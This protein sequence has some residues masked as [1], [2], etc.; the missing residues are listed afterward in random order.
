MSDF[1]AICNYCG[2]NFGEMRDNAIKL[3]LHIKNNHE[4]RRGKLKNC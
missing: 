4:H 1:D 2:I 3:S